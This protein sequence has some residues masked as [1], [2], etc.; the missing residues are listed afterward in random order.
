MKRDRELFA[1]FVHN[2]I[3]LKKLITIFIVKR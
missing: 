3:I 2:N 1:S